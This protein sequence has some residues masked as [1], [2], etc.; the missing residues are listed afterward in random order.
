M[1]KHIRLFSTLLAVMLCVMAFSMPAAAYSSADKEAAPAPE[2]TITPGE[3]LTGGGNLVT[4][5]LLYVKA[6]NKQ[7]I[8]V[9]TAE[10]D[11]FYIVIDYDKP[12]DEDGEQYQTYFLNLVDDTDL[13][14]L[15]GEEDEAPA[16]CTCA[17][18]C[19]AG[20]VD[21]SCPVCATDM[22]KCTGKAPITPE[23]PE[24][25]PT[26]E[27]EPEAKSPV[28]PAALVLVVLLLAGGGAACYVK[29]IKPKAQAKKTP[30]PDD[31]LYDDGP[32]WEPDGDG[33]EPATGD[34]G[35]GDTE[36]ENE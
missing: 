28:N 36:G 10:G 3:P 19:A 20:A 24:P 15:T 4:R 26:P 12:V 13:K 1:N 6:T 21:V 16:V 7:F 18:K 31:F 33:A 8:T 17:D 30:D 34:A 35:P 22:G 2:A 27:P 25:T 29:L 23:T 11:T 14:A 5:D 32:E 9:E